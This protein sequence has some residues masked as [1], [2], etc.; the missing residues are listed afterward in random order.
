MVKL[1]KKIPSAILQQAADALIEHGLLDPAS[2]P[3]KGKHPEREVTKFLLETY[4]ET[5]SLGYTRLLEA[6]RQRYGEEKAAEFKRELSKSALLKDP[7]AYDEWAERHGTMQEFF[8]Y[9]SIQMREM[10][11]LAMDLLSS[12]TLM[13]PPP[14]SSI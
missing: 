8:Q 2:L 5:V 13:E 14:F 12:R 9:T 11:E 1:S 10:F 3:K 4:R 7:E 6:L